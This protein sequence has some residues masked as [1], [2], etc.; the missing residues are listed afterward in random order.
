MISAREIREKA[1][2]IIN[3]IRRLFF[4][5]YD[6][7]FKTFD[8]QLE[9]LKNRGLSIN[10]MDFAKIVLQDISYYTVVNGYKNSLILNCNSD[11]FI[12]GTS[13]EILYTLHMV[14]ISFSS[15]L[16]KYI[17]YV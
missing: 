1:F 2:L 3:L 17:S 6:K 4:L 9:I 10:D 7:P 8:E 14:N 13:F 11:N 5:P 16:L 12:P 15:V